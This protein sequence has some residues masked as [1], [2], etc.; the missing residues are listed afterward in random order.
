MHFNILK[1]KLFQSEHTHIVSLEQFQI[2]KQNNYYYNFKNVY[3][4]NYNFQKTN[5][6]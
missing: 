5:R 1:C 2:M 6:L 3:F 4:K